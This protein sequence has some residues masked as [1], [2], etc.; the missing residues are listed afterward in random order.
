M[1]YIEKTTDY[2][3]LATLNRA[4]QTMHHEWHPKIFKPY[5]KVQVERAFQQTLEK[6]NVFAYAAFDNSI[7][8]GYLLAFFAPLR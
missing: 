3:L 4:I 5:D 8:V 6:E 7:A 2:Q 1:T